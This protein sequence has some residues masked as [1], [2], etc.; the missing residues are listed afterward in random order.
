MVTI[1]VASIHWQ[2]LHYPLSHSTQPHEIGS[3]H[4]H[5]LTEDG[6]WY[7]PNDKEQAIRQPGRKN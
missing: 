3:F 4:L 5:H 1:K 7:T 6:E 2:E